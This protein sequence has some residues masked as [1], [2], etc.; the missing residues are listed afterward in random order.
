MENFMGKLFL[1]SGAFSAY[2]NKTT[3]DIQAYIKFIKEHEN[4]IETYANLDDIGCPDKTWD[5][6]KEMERQGLHPI[7]VYHLNEDPKYLEMAMKYEYFAVGGLASAKGAGLAPFV[8]NVFV[9]LC[10]KESNYLPTHKVHGFGIAT[11][12][13]LIQFPWY[14]VDSTSWVMYGRYGIILVPNEDSRGNL[15]YENPPESVAISSRSKGTVD[16]FEHF[17]RLSDYRKKRITRYFTSKGFKLGKSL[18]KNVTCDYVLKPNEKWIDKD[19]KER[20]KTKPEMSLFEPDLVK[21]E[22]V[23]VVLEPGLQNNGEIRD[24]LNLIYFLDLE[25]Y[26][27]K[28][29]WPWKPNSVVKK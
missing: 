24:A 10:T 12:E 13:I 6:Q 7:P 3:V 14:S 8:R 26:Q 20:H 4:E 18:T 28:W 21:K 23:E 17:S 5:N 1:D 22:R 25:K 16:D 19:A 2:A 29:P 11:P 9:K 15:D 27:P